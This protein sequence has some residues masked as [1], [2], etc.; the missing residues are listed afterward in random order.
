MFEH[1]K[2]SR[3]VWIIPSKN[4]RRLKNEADQTFANKNLI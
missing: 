2:D 4:H 1:L 3:E